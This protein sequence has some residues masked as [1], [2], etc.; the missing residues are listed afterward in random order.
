MAGR[1]SHEALGGLRSIRKTSTSNGKPFFT[2][3]TVFADHIRVDTGLWLEE[4]G[5]FHA[6]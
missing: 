3:G 4:G 5:G 1:T 6:V 2:T